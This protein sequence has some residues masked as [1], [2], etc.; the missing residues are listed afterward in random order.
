MKTTKSRNIQGEGVK[1]IK[2]NVDEAILLNDLSHELTSQMNRLKTD[3][4]F[5]LTINKI[6]RHNSSKNQGFRGLMVIIKGPMKDREV[7]VIQC[8]QPTNQELII[9]SKK[10]PNL[11]S[12]SSSRWSLSRQN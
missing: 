9:V 1:V 8:F 6:N 11:R 5:T 7:S 2:G 12:K 4:H 10:A 3:Q